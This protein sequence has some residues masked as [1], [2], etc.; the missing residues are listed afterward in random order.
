MSTIADNHP[1]SDIDIGTYPDTGAAY[2]K[3]LMANPGIVTY[4]QLTAPYDSG[5]RTN[6]DVVTNVCATPFQKTTLNSEPSCLRNQR[7]N[8]RGKI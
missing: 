4:A 3:N 1:G 8:L 2:Q 7:H 6:P 5:R